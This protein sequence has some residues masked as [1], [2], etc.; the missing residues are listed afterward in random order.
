MKLMKLV[1]LLGI[2]LL[3]ASALAQTYVTAET[4]SIHNPRGTAELKLSAEVTAVNINGV[5]TT[6]DDL[7]TFDFTTA[8]LATGDLSTGATFGSG[9]VVMINAPTYADYIG[10]FS[11]AEWVRGELADGLYFY[12]LSAQFTSTEGTAAM[13]CKTDNLAKGKVFDTSAKLLE[14]QFVIN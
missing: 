14:C 9:G 7:G 1:I 8:A 10:N 5:L 12:V 13:V 4:G 2:L 11:T 6:G 3:S